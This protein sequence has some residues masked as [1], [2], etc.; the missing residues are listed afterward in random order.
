MTDLAT[1][2]EAIV[3]EIEITGQWERELLDDLERTRQKRLDLS[4]ALASVMHALPETARAPLRVRMQKIAA[5]NASGQRGSSLISDKVET[6]HAYLRAADGVVTVRAV[7]RH[8]ASRGLAAYPDAAALMLARKAKQGVVE[9]VA[10]GRYRVNHD[11]P[12]LVE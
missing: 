1:A 6:L 9:R 7:Q 11:H 3:A 4:R 10:R 5:A 12:M 8:L 2:A